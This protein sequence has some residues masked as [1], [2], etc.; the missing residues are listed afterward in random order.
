MEENISEDVIYDLADVATE[1][2]EENPDVA[3]NSA[4]ENDDHTDDQEN[5]EN[6]ENDTNA[7]NP[8]NA[9]RAENPDPAT[10]EINRMLEELGAETLLEIIRDNRNAAIRQI[11]SEVEASRDEALPSGDSSRLPCSSIFDLAALA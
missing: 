4:P 7:E 2:P 8:E 11:I 9:E 1:S 10:A 3:L 6:D 5:T